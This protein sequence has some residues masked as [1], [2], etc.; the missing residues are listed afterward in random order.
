MSGYRDKKKSEKMEYWC[1]HSFLTVPLEI[2]LHHIKEFLDKHP[3]EVIIIDHRADT[4]T[5]NGDKLDILCRYEGVDS[6]TLNL[7]DKKD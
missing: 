5:F 4:R 2:V 6:V 1:G 3:K 7:K